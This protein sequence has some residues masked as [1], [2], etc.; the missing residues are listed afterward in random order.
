MWMGPFTTQR[1]EGRLRRGAE[2]ATCRREALLRV[3]GIG[4]TDPKARLLAALRG[5]DEAFDTRFFTDKTPADILFGRHQLREQL[6]SWHI[7][8]EL[9]PDICRH[10]QDPAR[11]PRGLRDTLGL[12]PPAPAASPARYL[13]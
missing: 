13:G 12:G 8:A 1:R 10:C 3:V 9:V 7:P 4:R 11:R 5:F 2:T 6:L